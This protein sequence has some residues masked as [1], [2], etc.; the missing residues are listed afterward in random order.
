MHE[1]TTYRRVEFADTDMG[2]LVHFSRYFVFMETAEHELLRTLGADVHTAYDGWTI[3]WPR[4]S[5]SCEYLSPARFGD[6]LEINVRVE[7]K[8]RTSMTYGFRFTIGDRIVAR[9]R[10]T[11]TCCVLDD[12]AGLRAIPIPP[13]IADR[14]E[15]AP[16]GADGEPAS[17][18]VRQSE[19]VGSDAG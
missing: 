17:A 12:P 5:V 15:E 13:F 19:E 6:R 18:P 14:L 9:G 11:S 4:R 10:I 2:N 8:G 3:G 1:Y 7:R 16:G